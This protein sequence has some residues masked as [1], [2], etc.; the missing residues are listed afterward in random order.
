[1]LLQNVTCVSK[2]RCTQQTETIH[3][4]IY[5]KTHKNYKS[6][7]FEGCCYESHHAHTHHSQLEKKVQEEEGNIFAKVT[8]QSR[9]FFRRKPTLTMKSVPSRSIDMPK[10]SKY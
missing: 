10:G 4:Y 2:L 8:Q 6:K 9:T 1:M 3:S 7:P 5:R